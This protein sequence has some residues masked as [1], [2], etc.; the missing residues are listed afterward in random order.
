VQ[1]LLLYSTLCSDLAEFKQLIE[2]KLHNEQTDLA[3]AKTDLQTFIDNHT[4]EDDEF[5]GE[6]AALQTRIENSANKI[7][8]FEGALAR[9]K[10]KTYGV[11]LT[12][13]QLIDKRRLLAMPLALK[14]LAAENAA[15]K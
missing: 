11:C 2:T 5:L 8:G 10:Q 14:S 4:D 13:K 12:T 1:L 15:V 3:A 7:K 6:K 9:I